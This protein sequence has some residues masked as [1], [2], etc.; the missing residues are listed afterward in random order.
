MRTRLLGL[1]AAT[2]MTLGLLGTVRAG[3]AHAD[4]G[5]SCVYRET[6]DGV[7][8][9]EITLQDGQEITALHNG[10]YYH[11]RCDNGYLTFLGIDEDAERDPSH[12]RI[13]EI[14]T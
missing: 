1:G 6:T 5:A 8:T 7:V 3:V 2:A 13:R 4:G 12:V 10:H 14:L 11:W 9:Y